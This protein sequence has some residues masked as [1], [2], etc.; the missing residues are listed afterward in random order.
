MEEP[1]KFEKIIN[2]PIK[3]VISL[4]VLFIADGVHPSTSGG[5]QTFGRMLKK[6]LKEKLNFIDIM[7]PPKHKKIFEVSDVETIFSYN[8]FLKFVFKVFREGL[9][10]DISRNLLKRKIEKLNQDIFILRSP[11]NLKIINEKSKKILYQ[12]TQIDIMIKSKHYFNND[13]LLIEKC[14]NQLDYF[15]TPSPEDRAI[16]IKKLKFPEEKVVCIRHSCELSIKKEPKL[17]NRNL[18]MITR[19][20]NRGKRIDL[21]VKA[22]QKLENFHLNVYGDGKDKMKLEKLKKELKLTNVT[23]HGRTNE[24]KE[25]L[26]ENAI[27]IMTSD[28][29]GYGIT[30]VEAM[31]RGL[32]I[33][34]R[35][36]FE[37]AS[38][39][40]KGNG[41]L[42]KREWDEE[43]FIEAVYNVYKNYNSYSQNSIELGRRHNVEI[44]GKK[45]EEI[46]RKLYDEKKI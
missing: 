38:D 26:D 4:K 18:V 16:A 2:R 42:L 14:R 39:I 22:M 10:I 46:V 6:I 36:T 5:I 34:L 27:F 11:Q 20:E 23:F 7:N 41:V 28:Y 13:R 31:R 45:W 17:K 9:K 25:K 43:E 29:E 15:I 21:P 1:L 19:L 33:I 30:N 37:A 35:D 24:I 32:P 8:V 12:H 40:V 44:I 3:G